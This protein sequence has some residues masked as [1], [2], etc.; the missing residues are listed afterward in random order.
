MIFSSLDTNR[1][2]NSKQSPLGHYPSS[3]DSRTHRTSARDPYGQRSPTRDPYSH[4][5]P[6]RDSH[7]HQSPTR[8]PHS[9]RSSSRDPHR[10]HYQQQQQQQQYFP[11][12]QHGPL[13]YDHTRAPVPIQYVSSIRLPLLRLG[14]PVPVATAPMFTQPRLP[15]PPPG[16]AYPSGPIYVSTTAPRP[17]FAMLNL[18]PQLPPPT[19]L[20]PRATRADQQRLGYVQNI[21]NQYAEHNRPRLQLLQMRA[22]PRS[23]PTTDLHIPMPVPNVVTTSWDTKVDTGIQAEVPRQDGFIIEPG[24]FQVRSFLSCFFNRKTN[25]VSISIDYSHFYVMRLVS[26]LHQLKHIF[27]LLVK[28]NNRQLKLVVVN[29]QQ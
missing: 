19:S 26:I 4:R 16:P 1:T 10:H 21:M 11:Q 6:T 9:H 15:P 12:I 27:L 7:R 29:D 23:H 28:F 3:R 2:A 14:G 8:G 13:T 20:S 25:N 17:P 18:A 24:L 5:S 22:P